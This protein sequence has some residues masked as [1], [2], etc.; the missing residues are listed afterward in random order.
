MIHF[1]QT[2][3][4]VFVLMM[5]A[6]LVVAAD[7]VL[8]IHSVRELD[9]DHHVGL[10]WERLRSNRQLQSDCDMN[11]ATMGP[12]LGEL[13]KQTGAAIENCGATCNINYASYSAY[14]SYKNGCI[15]AKGAFATYKITIDCGI[16]KTVLSNFPVC[17]VSMKVFSGCTPKG[18]ECDLEDFFD[19]GIGECTETA[20]N[21]GYTDYSGSE[22]GAEPAPDGDVPD[23]IAMALQRTEHLTGFLTF[24]LAGL[25]LVC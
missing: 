12:A 14:T 8:P 7:P 21:T 15:A 16:A 13:D 5:S 18:F 17:L 4:L 25:F 19:F 24:F 6:M 3:S 10:V 23:S 11:S 20:T 9:S 22:Q 1:S 2:K